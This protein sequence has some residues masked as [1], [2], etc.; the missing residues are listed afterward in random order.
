[1]VALVIMRYK[2]KVTKVH[3]IR[4]VHGLLI[5]QVNHLPLKSAYNNFQHIHYAI[6]LTTVP[7]QKCTGKSVITLNKQP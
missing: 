5:T 2:N 4:T 1:M 6:V 7:G 3:K